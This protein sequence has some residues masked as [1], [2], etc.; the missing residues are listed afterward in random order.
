MS[1]NI[2]PPDPERFKWERHTAVVGP[3]QDVCCPHNPSVIAPPTGGD[4]P[5]AR[6]LSANLNNQ[7]RNYRTSGDAVEV[8]DEAST[9]KGAPDDVGATDSFWHTIAAAAADHLTLPL[10]PGPSSPSLLE[11]VRSQVS[12]TYS[13]WCRCCQPVYYVATFLFPVWRLDTSRILP[14][15]D[16][17]CIQ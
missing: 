5:Q 14:R 13:F 3:Q 2:Q 15:L 6:G 10:S 7:W 11:Q 16:V 9:Q 1:S 12:S 17:G 8:A 4:S